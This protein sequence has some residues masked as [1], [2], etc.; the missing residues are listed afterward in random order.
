MAI[1]INVS[2]KDQE[3]LNHVLE[4]AG[5]RPTRR[6]F[7]CTVGFIDKIIPSEEVHRFG[8]AVVDELQDLLHQRK[9]LYDVEKAAHLFRH[10]VAFLPTAQSEE[11]LKEINLWLVE[12]V[13]E[14]SENRWGLNEQTLPDT[15]TPHMTLWRTHRRDRRLKKLEEVA[16]AH[17]CYHLTQAAY[18]VFG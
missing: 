13:L 9:L 15:Y 1:K 2:L 7:H 5:Y 10:V 14:L 4:T 11:S 8:Q 6:K 17:P 12:K 3:A 18:V 16:S